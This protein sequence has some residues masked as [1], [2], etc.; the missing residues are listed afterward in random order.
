MAKRYEPT[1][2]ELL[3][4]A[5]NRVGS[6]QVQQ[7]APVP[8]VDA[9]GVFQTD[10]SGLLG[11]IKNSVQFNPPK[12]TAA[13]GSGASDDPSSYIAMGYSRD[14]ARRLAN[15]ARNATNYNELVYP[16]TKKV[17]TGTQTIEVTAGAVGSRENGKSDVTAKQFT[18][19]RT[20]NG[21]DQPATYTFKRD[22]SARTRYTDDAIKS[23]E[24][25]ASQASKDAEAFYAQMQAKQATTY[26]QE[27][28]KRLVA[29]AD[30]ARAYADTLKGEN[31]YVN[32][33]ETARKLDEAATSASDWDKFAVINGKGLVKF[34]DEDRNLKFQYMNVGERLVFSYY[35]NKGDKKSAEKYFDS[36]SH[37]LGQRANEQATSVAQAF[38]SEKNDAKL[39]ETLGPLYSLSG[40]SSPRV[41]GGLMYA[42]GTVASPQYMGDVV[43]GLGK[44]IVTGDYVPADPNT[45]KGLLIEGGNIGEEAILR[46]TYGTGRFVGETLLSIGTNVAQIAALGPAAPVLMAATAAG[47][48]THEAAK[49]GG[50][51]AQAT[52]SGV[53]QGLAEYF[54]EKVAVGNLFKII[55]TSGKKGI[56]SFVKTLVKNIP[57][58]AAA[59]FTEESATEA[60]NILSDLAIMGSKSDVQQYLTEYLTEN[61]EAAQNDQ[62]WAILGYAF[63]RIGKAGAQGAL[64]GLLMGAGGMLVS[65]DMAKSTETLLD[66]QRRQQKAERERQAMEQLGVML[67]GQN[68]QPLMLAEGGNKSKSSL[69]DTVK[70]YAQQKQEGKP[71]DV[72]VQYTEQDNIDAV[73]SELKNV[74]AELERVNADIINARNTYQGTEVSER[75]PDM[76]N[77]IQRVT[78]QRDIL[79]RRKAELEGFLTENK[80]SNEQAVENNRKTRTKGDLSRFLEQRTSDDRVLNED[81]L[82]AIDSVYAEDKVDTTEARRAL[83]T[84]ESRQRI[85]NRANERLANPGEGASAD[86]INEAR[87]KVVVAERQVSR[88]REAYVAA[89]SKLMDSVRVA[90]QAKTVSRPDVP[91]TI[92][93][94]RRAEQRQREAAEKQRVEAIRKKTKRLLTKKELETLKKREKTVRERAKQSEV[95]YKDARVSPDVKVFLDKIAEKLGVD[96]RI[97]NYADFDGQFRSEDGKGTIILSRKMLQSGT[98]A[99]YTAAHEVTHALEQT[100]LYSKLLKA[101]VRASNSQFLDV[102]A[103]MAMLEDMYN[104]SGKSADA[105]REWVAFYI[106]NYLFKSEEHVM[107]M[108]ENDSPTARGVLKAIRTKYNATK[109]EESILERRQNKA[110]ARVLSLWRRAMV[111]YQNGERVQAKTATV[112]VAKEGKAQALEIKG[113]T[114]DRI[115]KLSEK[116]RIKLAEKQ[117]RKIDEWETKNSYSI[118]NAVLKEK[119]DNANESIRQLRY[120]ID[121][122]GR[123]RIVSSPAP[124]VMDSTNKQLSTE[125]TKYFRYSKVRDSKG[126][127]LKLYHGTGPEFNVFRI[128]HEMGFHFGTYAQARN[129][130]GVRYGKQKKRLERVY[131]NITNPYRF[132]RDLMNW[133]APYVAQNILRDIKDGDY[134][135]FNNN[136]DLTELRRISAMN[137]SGYMNPAAIAMRKFF[138][139]KGYDGFVYPNGAEAVVI[140]EET[141][142]AIGGLKDSYMVFV[143]NQIKRVTNLSPTYNDDMRYSLSNAQL[144][145]QM[146]NLGSVYGTFKKDI[147]KQVSA[148]KMT[149]S[150]AASTMSLDS[151]DQRPDVHEG[152]VK[153]LLADGLS[154]VPIGNQKT[155]EAVLNRFEKYT[156][157]ERLDKMKAKWEDAVKGN[158]LPR[159]NDVVLGEQLLID[160]I[161]R[162]DV[163]AVEK[164]TAELAVIGTEA[165][166]VVQAF[167]MVKTLSPY[168]QAQ[169]MQT[170]VD[171]INDRNRQ[172]IGNKYKDIVIPQNMLDSLNA[173]RT[174]GEMATARNNIW[175]Y[176]A[177]NTPSTLGDK[178]RSWRYFA[179]LANPKTHIR[180]IGGNAIMKGARTIKDLIAT[181]IEAGAEKGGAI[182]QNQRTKTLYLKARNKDVVDYAKREFLKQQE[183][184]MSS[185]G[186]APAFFDRHTPIF[187]G[188]GKSEKSFGGYLDKVIKGVF[189]LLDA[190]DVIFLRDAFTDSYARFMVSRKY[191]PQFMD[192]NTPEGLRAREEARQYAMDQALKA[193]FRDASAFADMLNGLERKST[194]AQVLIGGTLPFK[195]TPWNILKRGVEYSPVGLVVG[196]LKGYHDFKVD[197]RSNDKTIRD[198]AAAKWIDKI[199]AGLT[200]SMIYGLGFFLASAG[201]ISVSDDDEQAKATFDR[202][203]GIQRYSLKIFGGTYTIDWMSPVNFPLLVGAETYNQLQGKGSG[204]PVTDLY[205]GLVSLGDP[206]LQL[207]ML[208]SLT[209]V[210]G[211]A[212][213]QTD[214]ERVGAAVQ[215]AAANYVSQFVPSILASIARSVDP[216]RRTTY[217]PKDSPYTKQGEQFYR[218]LLNK[219]PGLSKTLEPYVDLE[220]NTQVDNN[221]LAL[222]L[223][224]NLGSPGYFTAQ[225]Q[226]E[227]ITEILRLYESTGETSVLPQVPDSYIVLDGTRYDMQ[228]AE[229]TA[230]KMTV[231]KEAT[232]ATLNLIFT[233]YYKKASDEDKVELI[234]DAKEYARVMAK[235]EFLSA[236]GLT[237]TVDQW[238]EEYPKINLMSADEKDA[239]FDDKGISFVPDRK[240]ID[241]KAAKDAGMPVGQYISLRNELNTDAIS[242]NDVNPQTG[243]GIDGTAFKKK[244]D[245]IE[246]YKP[247]EAT[248]DILLSSIAEKERIEYYNKNIKASGMG[249]G[250]YIATYAEMSLI[251]GDPDGNGGTIDNTASARKIQYIKKSGYDDA[252]QEA[253]YKSLFTSTSNK[254]NRWSEVRA[255]SDYNTLVDYLSLPEEDFMVIKNVSQEDYAQA[256]QYGIDATQFI[257]YANYMNAQTSEYDPNGEVKGKT[258]KDKIYAYVYYLPNLSKEAKE[259]LFYGM[260]YPKDTKKQYKFK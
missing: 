94:Q 117:M 43:K 154:Y 198:M 78:S 42:L 253:L 249:V 33:E 64:S 24:N 215:N 86:T 175:I 113:Y 129:R 155:I 252:I 182:T 166:R 201:F 146:D 4:Y 257:E 224:Y 53:A 39:M 65:S 223:L 180:N 28:Y 144:K 45:P 213:G 139:D 98:A 14:A 131:L 41:R 120:Q 1:L 186:L 32:Q 245:L 3:G 218:S 124:S 85:L 134:G 25:V 2:D 23:A 123:I 125:Q 61:P 80:T 96:I 207:S 230:F 158:D 199:S 189:R 242:L 237:L 62:L 90:S 119:M 172:F 115:N 209:D 236:R 143:P 83:A 95:D 140:D 149:R 87:K 38:V 192:G 48:G 77:N 50:S 138:I 258:K 187:R 225:K 46:G 161:E 127:L 184:I 163:A 164:Y 256:K 196:T 200:G 173:A 171:R 162:N 40:L 211:S 227:E 100:K 150:F 255:I 216:V 226:S 20:E 31:Y 239:Y 7:N 82:D 190:E 177:Q 6:A 66:E 233:D 37:L 63:K 241:A 122:I 208:Q 197:M 212:F 68:T 228:P 54:G 191:T 89:Q 121:K 167:S 110:M 135:E 101:V 34:G 99:V 235:I 141:G 16:A 195:K 73:K 12:V 84:L 169:M 250:D 136:A 203:I 147:P 202:D 243:E 179:M 165:G 151:V 254:R 51:Y 88:A 102:D 168:W 145:A 222:R 47:Q 174:P 220:G 142:D 178:I 183:A 244:V 240:I 97:S 19:W 181:A 81:D 5:R 251:K 26:D 10:A 27:Q 105:A 153:Q 206:I 229:Y 157:D 76:L 11:F 133:E 15:E 108:L 159:L 193:T 74:N 60:A 22:T 111:R 132:D 56:K 116:Q 8:S 13:Q 70:T 107:D 69:L 91:E 106:Q 71:R 156:P 67:Q 17:N 114:Q 57:K 18:D 214:S 260:M 137:G 234:K 130:A 248:R 93:N 103:R 104:E 210:M 109:D 118:G 170:A 246:S 30:T 205:N 36:I 259:F 126:R 44:Q 55:E 35:Y 148:D 232:A 152:L 194:L 112:K 128:S 72:S 231:G 29:R 92:K 221:N 217:A 21:L 9:N 247:N 79:Q 219:I 58:Q 75:T 52:A 238:K 176:I 185:G 204:N 49:K 59:E 160:A 188:V